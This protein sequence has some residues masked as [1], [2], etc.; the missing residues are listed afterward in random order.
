MGIIV[1]ENYFSL[2]VCVC[3]RGFSSCLVCELCR[4]TFHSGSNGTVAVRMRKK[5]L[6]FFF[7]NF[8]YP[9]GFGPGVLSKS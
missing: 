2:C 6:F 9:P 3:V 5:C 8:L 1:Y 7:L 4:L